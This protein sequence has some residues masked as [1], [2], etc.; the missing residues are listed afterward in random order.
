MQ[1]ANAKCKMKERGAQES[2][3]SSVTGV[4]HCSMPNAKCKMKEGGTPEAVPIQVTGRSA[5]F[6]ANCQMQNERARRSRERAI[7]RHGAFN[8]R[9]LATLA[10]RHL[11]FGIDL[12]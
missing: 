12:D 5:I 7:Q 2:V 4:Q 8:T 1:N 9:I 6:N 3:Q 10:F 11:A